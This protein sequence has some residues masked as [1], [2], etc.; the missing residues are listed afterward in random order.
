MSLRLHRV[1]FIFPPEIAHQIAFAIL[2]FLQ[3]ILTLFG[4]HKLDRSAYLQLRKCEAIY[5]KNRVG[6]AAGLDK[7]ADSFLALSKLGFGFI[8]IGSITA[9]ES[10]G[11]T[12][13][14]LE[15]LVNK[16]ALVN[17]L[18]LPNIGVDKFYE[19]F[20]N[21]KLREDVVYGVNIA[22]TNDKNI[23]RDKA[24]EDFLYSFE[25]I[26]LLNNIDYIAL[27]I[28]C[29]N[30]EDGKTFEGPKDLKVL[31]G[32]IRKREG[33]IVKENNIKL[34]PV[35]VKIS[36]D[37]RILEL[38]KLIE[39][40]EDYSIYGY[41]VGNTSKIRGFVGYE[42]KID[43]GISG[44]PIGDLSTAVITEVYSLTKGEKL[45]IGCGGIF[46]AND[47]YEKLKA[48]ANLI[49]LYTSLVYQGPS[50]VNSINKELMK[51]AIKNIRKNNLDSIIKATRSIY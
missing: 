9:K 45:I 40:S 41:I 20:K 37:L 29:P 51:A 34:K 19:N 18:G 32:E 23:L 47:A 25:K 2:R 35:L 17:R 15:R 22:K 44:K 8:E 30:T 26:Y 31:L 43:G 24:I 46:D 39:V 3:P 27:N 50:V 11:N 16:E 42:N 33:Y 28:S 38:E 49:Q 1:L 36:P 10:K 6:L 5:F 21:K 7:N 13:E 12:G 48:G 14:V 4:S